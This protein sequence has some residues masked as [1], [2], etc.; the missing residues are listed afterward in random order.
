MGCQLPES[1]LH[2]YACKRYM[3]VRLNASNDAVLGDCGRYP[4][5]INATKL[6]VK[7]WLKILRM[8]DNRYVKKCT[9]LKCYA[10]AGVT[11]GPVV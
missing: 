7:Y 1:Y 3:C 9:M 10:D 6:C 5:Y 11:T 2:N 8:Q 4:M